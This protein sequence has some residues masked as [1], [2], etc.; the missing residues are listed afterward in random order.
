MGMLVLDEVPH[1]TFADGTHA[2]FFSRLPK[3]RAGGAGGRFVEV[4]R[5]QF[6]TRDAYYQATHIPI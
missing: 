3:P 4:K 6:S 1:K 5:L 2:V